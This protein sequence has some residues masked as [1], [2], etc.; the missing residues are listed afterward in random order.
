MA[1]IKT[2]SVPIEQRKKTTL[3]T[4]LYY[5]TVE[6]YD[7]K[8]V[9]Y[10]DGQQ[11]MA[12]YFKD[13]IGIDVIK[14][15]LNSQFAQIVF[16]TGINSKNKVVG[17]DLRSAQNM[18]AMNDTNRIL[19]CSGMFSFGKTNEFAADIADSIKTAFVNYKDSQ[20]NRESSIQ[21]LSQADELKKFKGLLDDGTITQAE[22][23]LKKKQILGL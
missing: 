8:A 17:V 14:A 11:K 1:L 2:V 23:D 18:N 3:A 4:N 6:V 15:G 20:E 13:Y 7:T 10:L 9:G 5:D 12:W 19:F 21:P 16:L 22:F